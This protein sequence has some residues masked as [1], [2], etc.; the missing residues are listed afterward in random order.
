VKSFCLNPENPDVAL[1]KQAAQIVKDGGLVAFPTETVYGIAVSAENSEAVEWLYKVKNRPLNKP[2][3]YHF[4]SLQ[5]FFSFAGAGLNMHI[6]KFVNNFCPGPITIIYND[7][8]KNK[9]IGIRIPD[10]VVAQ[11]FLTSC[12]VPVFAPSAN[13]SGLPSPAKPS[14]VIDYFEKKI[15]ALIDAGPCTFGKD[16]TVVEISENSYT[17]LRQGAV[18]ENNI[19]KY[20]QLRK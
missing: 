19:A 1:L 16:S 17:I 3:S 14:Q 11:V 5:D 6:R 9:K 18:D 20:F 2:F 12:A 13:P 7:S 8:V 10:N 15:D 4:G